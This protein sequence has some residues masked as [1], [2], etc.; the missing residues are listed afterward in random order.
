MKIFEKFCFAMKFLINQ[1]SIAISVS[2]GIDSMTL[3]LLTHRWKLNYSPKTRLYTFS[4][5]HM[6]RADA[7]LD[8]EL[9]KKVSSELGIECFTFSWERD[10]DPCSN[11]Q[12][13]ARNARYQLMLNACM[14]NNI[15][16]L[17][18]GHQ[19]NDNAENFFIRL[20]RGTGP[21]GLSSMRAVKNI[22]G[23]FIVRPML[24]ISRTEVEKY[25]NENKIEW[26][27]DYTNHNS[28]YKRTIFRDFLEIQHD[29]DLTLNRIVHCMDLIR[30]ET[31][32]LLHYTRQAAIECLKVTNTANINLNRESFHKFHDKTIAKL[33]IFS[34]MGVGNKWYKPRYKCTCKLL[35]ELTSNENVRKTLHGCKVISTKKL[36]KIEREPSAI[37]N[38]TGSPLEKIIWD[39]R[40]LCNINVKSQ[41]NVTLKPCALAGSLPKNLKEHYIGSVDALPVMHNENG[42]TIYPT[43]IE[44]DYSGTSFITI[45]EYPLVCKMRNMMGFDETFVGL[46]S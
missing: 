35:T 33:I 23:T 25:A 12:A 17:L 13:K 30:E 3:L 45:S 34:L 11:I 15:P 42:D 20:E 24:N 28:K 27:E 40:I 1:P 26:R 32:E 10:N 31:D 2:G 8:I 41:S 29:K 6:L 16:Y 22:N 19:K 38:H 36:I 18:L 37:E 4:V 14:Q 44:N 39:G 9:V 21:D 5:N 7:Y 46:F 43:H